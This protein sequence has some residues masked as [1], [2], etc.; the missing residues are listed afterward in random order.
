MPRGE[1]DPEADFESFAAAF[2]GHLET[3]VSALPYEV[4]QDEIEQA[5]GR[6][7]IFSEN[8]ILGMAQS[9][10]DPAVSASGAVSSIS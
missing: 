3:T 4:V 9:Q 2:A 10:V 5:K 6:A 1:V 8:L 7:E